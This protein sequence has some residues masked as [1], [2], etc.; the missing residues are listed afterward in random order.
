MGFIS[1]DFI[2]KLLD[3]ADI[4][5]VIG[6][7]VTLKRSGAN[8]SAK[9]PF[10][11]DKTASLM[12]SSAKNIWKDF[13]SGKGGN[14]VNFVMEAKPCSY[15]EAIEFIASMYNETV[16]YEQRE[17]TEK[18]KE[19]IEQKEVLRK[20]LLSVYESYSKEYQKLSPDHPARLEVEGKRL[21]DADIIA[22]WEIGFAPENFLYDKLE[23][24][25]KLKEGIAL[26]L[27][28]DENKY[29]KYTNRVIY[30]IRDS[31][32]LL[33]GFAGRDITGKSK[34]KWI[35]PD[36]NDLNVLYN[37]SKV[38]YGLD[39][40]KFEI[41]KRREAFISE[42]YNDVIAAHR[43]GLQNMLGSCGT[44]INELQINEI[45]KLTTN[46]VFW[47]DPDA[48]G[49]VAVLKQIPL[50]I[51]QGF[52]T[53]VI[54]TDFDPDDYCRK[55]S[56]VIALSGGLHN[57]FKTPGI[58][59]DGFGL[60]INEFIKKE[61]FELEQKL[62]V[63]RDILKNE[64]ADFEENKLDY[65]QQKN[66]SEAAFLEADSLL[67]KIVSDKGKKSEGYKKQNE[68][69][70]ALKAT[71]DRCKLEYK[72][73]TEPS[74]LKKQK[75]EVAKLVED[76]NIAFKSSEIKRAD[77]A[78]R[79]CE[80]IIN[81]QDDATFEIY[82][83]WIQKESG[84]LKTKLNAWIKEL[85]SEIEVV[86]ADVYTHY[87]LPKNIKIPLSDLKADIEH[88]GMFMANNQIFFAQEK[89]TDGKVNFSSMSN[90][91]IE[92]FTHMRDEKFP[93]KLLR[94]KNVHNL[95][96][97]FDT[98]SENLNTPQA[99]DNTVTAH[100]NFRF[101]GNRSDLL[102]LRTWLLDKMGNGRK[103][104]VLGWQPDGRF[105][106]WNN[107]ITTENGND[108]PINEHGIFTI[109]KTH[110]YVPSANQIY[111][112]NS[113]K[114]DAQ[115]RF[116][117][118][119]NPTSFAVFAQKVKEVHRDHAISALLFGVASIFQ[120]VVVE[121]LG[122][123]PLLFF[124]GPGSSGKDELA[125]IVQSFVGVPQVAINLEGNVSTIK[126]QVREF[127]QFRNG[128]SQLSEYKRGN[129][130]LD[131]MLKALWDRRGYKRGNIESHVGTDS[132][133]IE[134]SAILTG[135][136]FPNEEPLILRLI[137][138]EMDKNKF[139]Q[140]EMKAFDELRD[141]REK[142]VS[143]FSDDLFKQR[144]HFIEN[145]ERE[146]RSWKGI[147][148]E[149][150]PDAKSRIV[151]NLSILA[152][153]YSLFKD[154]IKFPFT[155]EEMINHFRK[156]IDQQI[157]KINSAS[158]LNRFWDCFIASLRGT[159]EQRLQVGYIISVSSDQLF[160][161][162]SHVYNKIQLEWIA[163]YKE[164]APTKQVIKDQL[165]ASGAYIGE[166][167]RHAFSPGRNGHSSSATVI[168][169]N[170]LNEDVKN[171]IIGSVMYQINEGSLWDKNKEEELDSEKSSDNQQQAL[172]LPDNDL[173]F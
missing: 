30:P 70:V 118:I 43:Y 110:Y 140:E 2:D 40:A 122:N 4:V 106:C 124:F 25:G 74:Q 159:K 12:V 88:Y 155:Q 171:D 129:P 73:Y 31:R 77:G 56:D 149:L 1:K 94:V 55:Y 83:N 103:I 113:F 169:L 7:L 146:Q 161:Q 14:M 99:F 36:V 121:K 37:K 96:V 21:Y 16:E 123:F 154:T 156:G 170:K 3:R 51:K 145:F 41:R 86:D 116:R 45:K 152:T 65:L 71:F 57:M 32:G 85:R 98:P 72:N 64:I 142:G 78:K 95:E 24:S 112:N 79:L 20:V 172:P 39:K 63:Q 28:K 165:I 23:K 67:K 97:I 61:Y 139:N 60:L 144:L 26:G 53:E 50:F 13:S 35:N 15:P 93:M 66:L 157:R 44:S 126:A 104:D 68:I 92:V 49:K 111:K 91:E 18:Q 58:R 47:M 147:L 133:P 11:D 29:D 127:A 54:T 34:A 153:A 150:F 90:F 89:K 33:I 105:W 52:F 168:N 22:E 151:S 5:E 46:A 115:K 134:S 143:C 138:N 100:G 107:K 109:E 27:I 62:E 119:D 102:R 76:Y 162:W 19:V 128:I 164:L 75:L 59:Q 135:N 132:I 84:I 38:W 108:I 136:D 80:I 81:I 17:F 101:D 130:Q 131:G 163:R 137:W 148:Q 160:M 48:A 167:S 114:Y 141:M 158:I 120:D 125:A 42:G 9:S 6:K 87:E 69:T 117:K 82:F 166:E 10:S 173:P 8:M